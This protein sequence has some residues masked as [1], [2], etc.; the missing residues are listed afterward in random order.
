M[1]V[2]K[3]L[4][5]HTASDIADEMGLQ[6]VSLKLVAQKLNIKTPSLYNHISSLDELLQEI[7]HNGMKSMNEEMKS[8]A[9][10]KAGE[11]SIKALG[12]TYLQYVVQHPGIYET[13]QWVTWHG[14]DET[15][16]IFQTYQELLT[17]LI[18]S[19]QF[20]EDH[21]PDIL[22]LLTGFLHGYITMNLSLALSDYASAEHSL[23]EALDTIFMGLHQKYD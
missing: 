3:E 10:G 16:V 14:T 1:R 12:S 20:Q 13:I 21:I 22:S 5:I 8:S 4:I 17:T 18:R 11:T 19:C 2:S 15:K 7:A 23:C 9:I 6:Q